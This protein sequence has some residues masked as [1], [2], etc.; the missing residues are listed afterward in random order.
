MTIGPKDA[1]LP[2]TRTRGKTRCAWPSA[3][4]PRVGL[5]H[6][7]LSPQTKT[8]ELKSTL[9]FSTERQ[10]AGLRREEGGTAHKPSLNPL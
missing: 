1:K 3:P 5:F 2:T 10:L 6:H 8:V 9:L 7:L 4:N